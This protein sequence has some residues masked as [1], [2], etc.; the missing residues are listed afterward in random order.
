[1]GA[2]CVSAGWCCSRNPGAEN[3]RSAGQCFCDQLVVLIFHLRLSLFEMKRLILRTTVRVRSSGGAVS[4]PY[5]PLT[6]RAQY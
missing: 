5:V 4:N 1:V 2:A 3:D 6:A